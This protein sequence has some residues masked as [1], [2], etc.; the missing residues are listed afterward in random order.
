VADKW[1]SKP[2]IYSATN[3]AIDKLTEVLCIVLLDLKI[4]I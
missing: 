1:T 2:D 3:A 4:T